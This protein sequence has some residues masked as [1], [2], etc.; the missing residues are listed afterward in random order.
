MK[1]RLD[2]KTLCS[3]LRRYSMVAP[4]PPRARLTKQAPLILRRASPDPSQFS[5][6]ESRLKRYFLF[7]GSAEMT[8]K[9]GHQRM[10]VSPPGGRCREPEQQPRGSL[11]PPDSTTSVCGLGA[12]W[13]SA[14][15][16]TG[17]LDA[18]GAWASLEVHHG[19][20]SADRRSL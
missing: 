1:R 9:R 8:E 19:L 14:V 12:T 4:S 15:C 5:G 17:P 2:A 11:G 3:H 13:S 6:M 7:G 10:M 16:S 20:S 18:P